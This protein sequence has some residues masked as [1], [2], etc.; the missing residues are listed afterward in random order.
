M[1]GNG[2]L[3]PLVSDY[4]ARARPG[5]ARHPRQIQLAQE[6]SMWSKPGAWERGFHRDP[7]FRCRRRRIR[8]AGRFRLARLLSLEVVDAYCGGEGSLDVRFLGRRFQHQRGPETSMGE[9]LR[10]LA[11]LP[12]AS[13][14][15]DFSD[16]R[17]LG[18]MRMPTVADVSWDIPEG[19]P[20]WR[21]RIV[22]ARALSSPFCRER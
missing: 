6:G 20:Y 9:A 16:Y 18:G 15:G 4:L 17:E 7:A 8:V 1:V 2:A 21:E 22:A 12:R 19:H 3:Q 10:Y 14:D 11:E 5:S 13:W